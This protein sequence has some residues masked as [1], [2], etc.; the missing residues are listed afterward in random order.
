VKATPRAAEFVHCRG[1]L[2]PPCRVHEASA[3]GEDVPLL[4]EPLV[5]QFF[6]TRGFWSIESWSRWCGAGSPRQQLSATVTPQPTQGNMHWYDVLFVM[7]LAWVLQMYVGVPR[8]GACQRIPR[9][10]RSGPRVLPRAEHPL[11]ARKPRA[12]GKGR[13]TL[14]NANSA[15]RG[16]A[17]TPA[18][19]PSENGEAEVPSATPELAVFTPSTAPM[20]C[21][22]GV[23]QLHRLWFWNG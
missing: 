23:F 11:Q 15:A 20:L 2:D 4:A 12:R 7:F 6:A 19:T 13:G 14:D 10:P 8:R 9:R 16:V 18:T 21:S 22:S 5:S 3:F 1:Y 17:F